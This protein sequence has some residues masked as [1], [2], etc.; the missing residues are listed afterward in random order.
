VW[1]TYK[2][3]V[4]K[5][6]EIIE[7]NN[8]MVLATCNKNRNPWA[9]VVFYAYDYEYNFYFISAADSLH[10]KNLSENPN[11]AIA[12]FDS[13]QAFGLSEGVQI[14]GTLSEMEDE[15]K[16]SKSRPSRLK[17]S[18]Y[19]YYSRMFPSISVQNEKGLQIPEAPQPSG[20]KFVKL[21]VVNAY[22]TK[23]NK[24]TEVDLKAPT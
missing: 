9:S 11:V 17:S 15:V 6:K 10:V 5:A 19:A 7:Q 18:M 13:K 2:A 20:L 23:E 8:Y 14:E 21:A 16:L 24:R 4:L 22:L 12:I 3:Y 1:I